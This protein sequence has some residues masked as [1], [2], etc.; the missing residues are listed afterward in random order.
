M[1][2]YPNF[3]EPFQLH[4]DASGQGLGAVLEQQVDGVSHPVAFVSRTLLKH[5]QCYGITELETLAVVWGLRHYRAYL[6]GHRV[7]VFTDHAPVK[8]LLKTK[9]HSGKAHQMG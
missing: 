2:A 6:Y 5:E 4:T 7:T 9:H 8:S 3:N 1:L